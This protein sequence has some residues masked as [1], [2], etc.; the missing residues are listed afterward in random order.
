M[1]VSTGCWDAPQT[2]NGENERE[3]EA[4]LKLAAHSIETFGALL[5]NAR[6]HSRF[7]VCMS[8]FQISLSF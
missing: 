5:R 3:G 2:Q 6:V 7:Q 8:R 4:G 1:S